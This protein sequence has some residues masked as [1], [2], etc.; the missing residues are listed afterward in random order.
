MSFYFHELGFLED[1]IADYKKLRLEG[2]D[3]VRVKFEE[4]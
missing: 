1:L 4:L 2:E 3:I